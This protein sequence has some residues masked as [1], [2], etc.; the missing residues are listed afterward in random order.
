MQ[1]KGYTTVQA[2][3]DSG[4]KVNVMTSAYMAV[5]GLR[6]CFTDVRAQKIDG[7]ML[8]TYGKV[9]AIFQLKDK[10]RRTR[11]F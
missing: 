11:F 9:L 2:L 3:L 4:S 6:V 7:S 1:F 5:L 8:L 10:Q